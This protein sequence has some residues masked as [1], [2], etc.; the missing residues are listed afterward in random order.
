MIGAAT[1]KLKYLLDLLIGCKQTGTFRAYPY[2]DEADE[3]RGVKKIHTYLHLL[4]GR[5]RQSEPTS[6]NE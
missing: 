2:P 5:T 4:V 3:G 1:S 6:R